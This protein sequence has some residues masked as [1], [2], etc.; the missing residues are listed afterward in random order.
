M[1]KKFDVNATMIP[2][3]LANNAFVID[4]KYESH[5]PLNERMLSVLNLVYRT[6]HKT[7]GK[8]RGD[9]KKLVDVG[10]FL[11]RRTLE[12]LYHRGLLAITK[13][14]TIYGVGG[15]YFV[16]PKGL[17]RLLNT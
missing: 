16:S 3:F 6:V 10:E 13:N 2:R 4:E 15:H 11:D 7:A 14:D 12:A 8:H 17:E 5:R 9:L 1:T